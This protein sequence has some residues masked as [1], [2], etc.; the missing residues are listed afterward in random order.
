MI[1]PDGHEEEPWARLGNKVD[2]IHDE[3]PHAIAFGHERLQQ[4]AEVLA[5]ICSNRPHHIFQHDQR[6][7][8]SGALHPLHELPASDKSWQGNEAHA[9]MAPGGNCSVVRSQTSSTR[10]SVAGAK[11]WR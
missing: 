4:D 1:V 3:R 7:R 11:F 10:Y 2:G 8:S 6:D 9:N 5:L